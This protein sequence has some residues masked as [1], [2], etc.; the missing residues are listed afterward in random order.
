MMKL[1][2]RPEEGEEWDVYRGYHQGQ[3][4][5]IRI[6]HWEGDRTPWLVFDGPARPIVM[7]GD[8]TR[9][10]RD[11]DTANRVAVEMH[12]ANM[13]RQQSALALLNG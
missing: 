4:T 2:W 13:K 3:P 1:E 8:G 5:N 6:A 9:H 10:C 12:L 11:A 7:D